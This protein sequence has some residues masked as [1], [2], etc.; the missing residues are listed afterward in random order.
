ML[1]YIILFSHLT[2][3]KSYRPKRWYINYMCQ[4]ID[5]DFHQPLNNLILI[6]D[7]TCVINRSF[8]LREAACIMNVIYKCAVSQ[9]NG[10]AY[11][12]NNKRIDCFKY[13][14]FE[15][16]DVVYKNHLI[17]AHKVCTNDKDTVTVIWYP[18]IWYPLN[19]F[20]N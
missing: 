6:S 20:C 5:T 15:C 2:E 19:K 14:R 17:Q 7:V 9:V 13:S 4:T 10:T 3:Q 16:A 18:V 8:C 1:E 11:T 12:R